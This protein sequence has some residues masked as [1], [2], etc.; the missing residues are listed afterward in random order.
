MDLNKPSWPCAGLLQPWLPRGLGCHM[1]GTLWFWLNPASLALGISILQ[2]P[3]GGISCSGVEAVGGSSGFGV[4]QTWAQFTALPPT[5]H[6]LEQ[7]IFC[8]WK[9]GDNTMSGCCLV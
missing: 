3:L 8:I 4:W 1:G 2:F 9:L 6:V 5:K 7:V